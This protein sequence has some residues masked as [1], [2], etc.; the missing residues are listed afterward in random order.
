MIDHYGKGKKAIVVGHD[1]G[2]AV[3]WS[4]AMQH[5]DR[6]EKLVILNLPHPRGLMRGAG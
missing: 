4:F 5:P 6:L 3:A 2:G 1:W